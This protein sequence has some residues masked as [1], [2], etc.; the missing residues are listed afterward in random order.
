MATQGVRTK[1]LHPP[2]SRVN[3]IIL[4]VLDSYFFLFMLSFCK[5]QYYYSGREVLFSRG[6]VPSPRLEHDRVLTF[7][8]VASFLVLYDGYMHGKFI[9]RLVLVLDAVRLGCLRW[10][11]WCIRTR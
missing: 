4:T 1:A 3:S 9:I 6:G 11:I 2:Q 10:W 8:F 7:A 5:L